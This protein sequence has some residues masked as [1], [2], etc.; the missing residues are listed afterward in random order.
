MNVEMITLKKIRDVNKRNIISFKYNK[1]IN[2]VFIIIIQFI[3]TAYNE[4]NKINS[5]NFEYRDVMKIN[6]FN[7]ISIFNEKLM[8]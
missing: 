4:I 7:I 3:K 5:F 6:L 1:N 2:Y 8:K